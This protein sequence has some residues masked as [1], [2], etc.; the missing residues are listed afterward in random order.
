MSDDFTTA[1]Y[2]DS[3]KTLTPLKGTKSIMAHPYHVGQRVCFRGTAGSFVIESGEWVKRLDCVW[4]FMLTARNE[5]TDET[6]TKHSDQIALLL[7]PR[8]DL[9]CPP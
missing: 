8:P 9:P 4:D 2:T 1:D 6:V 7:D 3:G 5:R